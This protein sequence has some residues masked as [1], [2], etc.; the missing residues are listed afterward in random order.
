MQSKGLPFGHWII[1]KFY[2]KKYGPNSKD[3]NFI[4]LKSP[5]RKKIK[6]LTQEIRKLSAFKP[7]QDRRKDIACY[8][9]YLCNPKGSHMVHWIIGKLYA[10]S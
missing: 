7:F 10:T 8:R 4:S 3:E 1:A 9:G 5:F 6:T 2:A